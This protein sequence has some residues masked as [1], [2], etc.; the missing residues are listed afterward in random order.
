MTEDDCPDGDSTERG[1]A[2][3][4][5]DLF[6]CRRCGAEWTAPEEIEP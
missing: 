3:H 5:M 4:D 1:Y 6:G 2:D